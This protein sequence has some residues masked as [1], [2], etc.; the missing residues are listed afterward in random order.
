MATVNTFIMK[1]SDS[2]G[3][4]K[5]YSAV[6]TKVK[7]DRV[8]FEVEYFALIRGKLEAMKKTA[9]FFIKRL[10]LNPHTFFKH[11]Q[12][13]DVKVTKILKPSKN[14]YYL[15][16]EV[17]PCILPADEFIQAHPVGSMVQG[18]IES[19]TGATMTVCLAPNVYAITKRCNHARTGR[20]IDCKI[21]K[22]H[23]QKIS[24]R[25]I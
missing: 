23:N 2:D 24:L 25:V 5:I 10:R 21:D 9:A 3:L 22:F 11:G 15:N 19:L 18:K 14:F 1:N 17:I 16:Y 20:E 13:I 8:F 4:G 12:I 6:I 7:D